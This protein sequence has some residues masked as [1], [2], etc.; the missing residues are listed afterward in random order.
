MVQDFL[1]IRNRDINT[2]YLI[3]TNKED[4]MTLWDYDKWSLKFY[5]E[6]EFIFFILNYLT[7][8]LNHTYFFTAKNLQQ[9]IN[10]RSYV[11]KSQELSLMEYNNGFIQDDNLKKWDMYIVSLEYFNNQLQMNVSEILVNKLQRTFK[12]EKDIL[13]NFAQLTKCH[14]IKLDSNNIFYEK[15]FY[16]LLNAFRNDYQLVF[17]IYNNQNI[18]EGFKYA[19]QNYLKYV[20]LLKNILANYRIL[21][22]V[23]E[24]ICT[25]K[26]DEIDEVRKNAKYN[27]QI[28]NQDNNY[29]TIK[30]ANDFLDIKEEINYLERKRS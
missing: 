25:L 15:I 14:K 5:S 19:L 12:F 24:Q 16:S 2:A 4:Y 21:R 11:V 6:K 8:N 13:T 22:S 9:Y 17:K 28:F 26:V 1:V 18:F 3:K 29:I 7:S 30:Q 10:D 27:G 23:V 20:L